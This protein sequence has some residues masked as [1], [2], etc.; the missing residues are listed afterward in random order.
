MFYNDFNCDLNN[1]NI[2][3]KFLN[4]FVYTMQGFFFGFI[5]RLWL[6]VIY[7]ITTLFC[8]P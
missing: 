5:Q 4:V 3:V 2:L 7:N 8:A 6:Q 1:K